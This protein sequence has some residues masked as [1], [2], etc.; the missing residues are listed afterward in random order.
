MKIFSNPHHESDANLPV[1]RAVP[2]PTAPPGVP[3]FRTSNDN[4]S[5]SNGKLVFVKEK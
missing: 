4:I 3:I 2:Q 1:F 5:K